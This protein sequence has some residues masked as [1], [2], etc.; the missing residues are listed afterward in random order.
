[1]GALLCRGLIGI[2]QLISIDYMFFISVI[3]LRSGGPMLKKTQIYPMKF[4][5]EIATMHTERMVRHQDR[6]FKY[7]I[8]E[9]YVR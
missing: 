2:P 5:K 4:G 7:I 6:L 9:L 1:M 8:S 3:L